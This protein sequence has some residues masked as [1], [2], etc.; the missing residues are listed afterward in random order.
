MV[1]F[2]KKF[3][4]MDS[5]LSIVWDKVPK[6]TFFLA[7]SLTCSACIAC[8]KCPSYLTC[9]SCISCIS[10]KPAL[11]TLLVSL[12]KLVLLAFLE[13]L[14]LFVLLWQFVPLSLLDSCMI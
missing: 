3:G 4:T 8:T 12:A 1:I 9:I 11:L 6:K 14:V 5:H 7:P 10:C 13:S 2:T